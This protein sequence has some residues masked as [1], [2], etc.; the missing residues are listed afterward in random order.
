MA[1]E[2]NPR[3]YYIDPEDEENEEAISCGTCNSEGVL[4]TCVDD[5]C[6]GMEFCSHRNPGMEICSCQTLEAQ[7]LQS[8]N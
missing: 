8:Q 7:Q 2:R 6:K 5:T 1:E 3:T 4:I